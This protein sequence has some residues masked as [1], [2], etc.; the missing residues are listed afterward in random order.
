MSNKKKDSGDYEIFIGDEIKKVGTEWELNARLKDPS[1]SGEW[2]NTEGWADCRVDIVKRGE[3][4][5]LRLIL[6]HDDMQRFGDFLD[7]ENAV[8]AFPSVLDDVKCFTMVYN[9]ITVVLNTPISDELFDQLIESD[10]K[11][12]DEEEEE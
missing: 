10:K 11:K 6:N 2:A 4:H 9:D 7:I 12:K 5:R 8:F 1:D 3:I